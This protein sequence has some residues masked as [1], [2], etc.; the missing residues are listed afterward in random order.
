MG[1]AQPAGDQLEPR[2]DPRGC[3]GDFRRGIGLRSWRQILS[4]GH[5]HLRLQQHRM[6]TGR[7]IATVVKELLVDRS[8]HRIRH[9][10]RCH[11]SRRRQSDFEADGRCVRQLGDCRLHI[12]GFVDGLWQLDRMHIDL[13]PL[14]SGLPKLGC[15][16]V[17]HVM[18]PG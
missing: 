6:G 9:S 15:E 11:G 12:V 17:C 2:C 13:G 10:E 3:G 14:Q 4:Q 5:E 16:F 8:E 1:C 7:G 18:A